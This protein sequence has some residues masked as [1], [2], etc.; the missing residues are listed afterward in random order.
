MSSALQ[1]LERLIAYNQRNK[2]ADVQE[3]LAFMQF[4][5]QKRA[6]EIKEFGMQM[7]MLGNANKQFK[8]NVADNFIKNSG[9]QSIYNLVPTGIKEFDTAEEELQSIVTQLKKKKV[10]GVKAKFDDV[11]ANNIAAALWEYKNTQDPS[12]IVNLSNRVET[13]LSQTSAPKKGSSDSNLLNAFNKISNLSQLRQVGKQAQQTLRDETN[14]LKEQFEFARGDT[15]IQSGF[16]MFSDEVAR[17]FED[18]KPKPSDE[19]TKLA[20]DFTSFIEKDA[21]DLE[22]EDKPTGLDESIQEYNNLN[23]TVAESRAELERLNSLKRQGFKVDNKRISDLNEQIESSLEERNS[24]V[25]LASEIARVKDIERNVS[26]IET[27]AEKILE[28][29]ELESTEDNLRIAKARAADVIRQVPTDQFDPS[30]SDRLM[31]T[32]PAYDSQGRI[33]R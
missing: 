26:K 16:G 19:I 5:L 12:S 10:C 11:N 33:Q 14:I 28:D 23:D 32:R 3:S 1:A 29:N 8:L 21:D 15:K 25:G 2:R 20:D 17:E 4:G 18:S 9:L 22:Y 30:I 7:E 6:A 13:V 27:L 31:G 24:M